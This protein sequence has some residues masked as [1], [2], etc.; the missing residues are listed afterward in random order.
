MYSGSAPQLTWAGDGSLNYWDASA[1]NWTNNP[2]GGAAVA[3][4]NP[5]FAIFDDTGSTNPAVDIRRVGMPPSSV[6][7]SNSVKNYVLGANSGSAG[8]ISGGGSLIA[9]GT[10]K[11]TLQTVNDYLGGTAISNNAVVQLG[12]N[13]CRGRGRH[14][15]HR[16]GHRQRHSDRQ[17][18]HQ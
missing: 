4:A 6:I 9:R 13:T 10:G 2:P 11:V 15:W 12:N 8:K 7:F 1:L 5:D 3:F 18:F 16:A 17:Q 14:A